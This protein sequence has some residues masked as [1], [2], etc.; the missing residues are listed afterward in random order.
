VRQRAY[1][2]ALVLVVIVL[3]ISLLSRLLV[4]WLGRYVI[5]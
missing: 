4:R 2:A 5:R 1:A 3:G